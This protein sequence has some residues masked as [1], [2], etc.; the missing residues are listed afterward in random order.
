VPRRQRKNL[1]HHQLMTET[2]QQLASRFHP[3]VNMIKK[4]I[5]ALID[6]EYLERG[7]NPNTPSYTYLA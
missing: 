6:R 1:S 3:D 5:E 2:I 4:K 7:T